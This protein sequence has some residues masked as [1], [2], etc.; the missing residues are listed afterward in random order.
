MWKEGPAHGPKASLLSFSLPG[1]SEECIKSKPHPTY[2]M[3]R[4][5]LPQVVWGISGFRELIWIPT[6]RGVMLMPEHCHHGQEPETLSER[7]SWKS[8]TCSVPGSH[9]EYPRDVGLLS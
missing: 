3:F 9:K 5:K 1:H 8:V 7:S 6:H 4:A 2:S